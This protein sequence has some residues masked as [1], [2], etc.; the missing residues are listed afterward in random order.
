MT[1]DARLNKIIDL[2]KKGML[3]VEDGISTMLTIS[4]NDEALAQAIKSLNGLDK[5][6]E[7][8]NEELIQKNRQAA[9][10]NRE[11]LNIYKRNS[12]LDEQAR[13][14]DEDLKNKIEVLRTQTNS[15]GE[16]IYEGLVDEYED[17]ISKYDAN[18]N[19][20]EINKKY[21]E[22]LDEVEK[23][24]S[25]FTKGTID[26]PAPIPVVQGEPIPGLDEYELNK[27]IMSK[28]YVDDLTDDEK[29]TILR[30]LALGD[31]HQL[32]DE[33]LFEYKTQL[34]KNENEHK[35]DIMNKS[36][37]QLDDKDKRFIK[38]KLGMDANSEIGSEDLDKFKNQ[39]LEE[40]Q[41]TRKKATSISQAAEGLKEKAKANWDKVSNKA[42][43]FA[44]V[45]VAAAGVVTIATLG[46]AS[47]GFTALG[48]AATA[49]GAGLGVA[50]VSN[51][52]TGKKL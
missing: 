19:D 44:A 10:E 9:E 1:N 30:G 42:K 20:P 26:E 37:D 43:I 47:L 11:R 23:T 13:K 24:Y 32:T 12:F 36:V 45:A 16:A 51:Y 49:A 18:P 52:N 5:T 17:I 31:D 38:D 34:Q 25:I 46:A 40:A 33:D 14:K 48:A 4:D 27:S 28:K 50:T 7:D 21:W 39:L 22:L 6:W 8:E 2:C 29:L 41:G 35:K 3:D 15:N